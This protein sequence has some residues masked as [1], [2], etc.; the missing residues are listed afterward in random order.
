MYGELPWSKVVDRNDK[1]SRETI[2]TMKKGYIEEELGALT[3]RDHYLRMYF[4]EC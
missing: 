1:E 4:R 3:W 2:Y